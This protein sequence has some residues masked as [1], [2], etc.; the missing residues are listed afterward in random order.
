ME[1]AKEAFYFTFGSDHYLREG[2]AVF[3]EREPDQME[4]V[5]TPLRDR[6][7]IVHAETEMR[8]RLRFISRL[9]GNHWSSTY[10]ETRGKQIAEKYGLTELVLDPP[11]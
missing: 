7:I 10:D 1:A 2:A 4:V 6:Y 8:A 9:C 11:L 3:D 5:G